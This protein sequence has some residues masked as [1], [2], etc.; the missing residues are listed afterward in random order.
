VSTAFI[1]DSIAA[2][3]DPF[4]NLDTFGG[5]GQGLGQES[6]ASAFDSYAAS[7]GLNWTLLADN[8]NAL[9]GITMTVT[10]FS[11]ASTGNL[12]GIGALN[13]DLSG[14]S[15][16]ILDQLVWIQ[17]LEINYKPGPPPEGFETDTNYNTLDDWT[18]NGFPSGGCN[19][20]P[21]GSPATVP[22]APLPSGTDYCDPI[23]PFQYQDKTFFD[24]PMGAWPNASFRGVAMLASIDTTNHIVT[25][26]GGVSYGFDNS[27]APEPGTWALLLTGVAGI[28][29]GRRRLMARG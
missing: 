12:G 5:G 18:F 25:T 19:A 1:S 29:I 4:M 3:T 22:G 2:N 16:S 15:Q 13:V 11:A 10:S 6:F 28:L 21:D 7:S 17:G 27:V 23:Y 9:S 24:A 8:T 14:A 26:Y 20:V